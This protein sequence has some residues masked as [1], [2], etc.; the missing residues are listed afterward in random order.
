MSI[1]GMPA[2]LAARVPSAADGPAVEGLLGSPATRQ[3]VPRVSTRRPS[4]PSWQASARGRAA[5]PRARRRGAPLRLALGARPR[6]GP[7][8]RG[9]A[10]APDLPARDASE[11]A[12]AL[13]AAAERHAVDIATTA[14]AG[15]PAGPVPTRTTPVSRAGSRRRVRPHTDVD[16]DDAGRRPRGGDGSSAAQSGVVVR[17]VDQ[18][19][20]GLP[21]AETCGWCTGCSRSPSRTTSARTGELPRVRHAPAGG[22]RSPLGPLVARERPH[23]EGSCPPGRSSARCCGPTAPAPRAPTST[24]S[25]STVAR[26]AVGSPRRCC[27]P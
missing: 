19:D 24:T 22:P 10:V 17:P 7:H 6:V 11:L 25:A 4:S 23:P 8:A 27:T 13:F 21:V 9:G 1:D 18:H 15:D 26:V 14:A 5:R 2:G 16:A 20:D 3:G 12:L